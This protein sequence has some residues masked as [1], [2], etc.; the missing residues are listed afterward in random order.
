M[1]STVMR[2]WWTGANCMES[3][4]PSLLCVK[5]LAR[6]LGTTGGG[7]SDWAAAYV[8]SR[9]T[10]PSAAAS[11]P[12]ANGRVR[13]L[14][15]V[16]PASSSGSAGARN[17][18]IRKEAIRWDPMIKPRIGS[19]PERLVSCEMLLDKLTHRPDNKDLKGNETSSCRRGGDSRC[20]G[21]QL[22]STEETKQR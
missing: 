13:A 22:A 7:Q 2:R 21:A 12:I 14:I 18:M 8:I 17:P 16:A 19:T 6:D 11:D 5:H 3:G 10:P 4:S 9:T 20:S 1:P 15:A